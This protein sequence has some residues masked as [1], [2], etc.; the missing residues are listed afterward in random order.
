MKA[1]LMA[2]GLG[3]RLY[4]LTLHTPKCLLPIKGVPLLGRWLHKLAASGY[5]EV[6]INLHHLPEQVQA[7]VNAR[8]WGVQVHFSYEK[9]LLGSLGTLHAN[10]PLLEK[11]PFF[12]VA[13]ADN[14][15]DM[16]LVSM[17]D[18]HRK[19]KL[20]GT[21]ALF[22]ASEPERCGIVSLDQEQV[23]T[24]FEEKPAAPRSRLAN[25][26]I[27]LFNQAVWEHVQAAKRPADIGYDLLPRLTGR[28][29]GFKL[30]GFFMDIGTPDSLNTGSR[31]WNDDDQSNPA[32][33]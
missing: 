15:T 2:A 30:D 9:E 10:R 22:E 29:K 5:T 14:L 21:M 3:T 13:Y 16:D 18:Y 25:A 1:I 8:E 32:A 31:C 28:L 27:Y 23:V 11:D 4:P 7:Y 19:H 24:E 17:L 6:I 33:D 26:G 20:A 12:L